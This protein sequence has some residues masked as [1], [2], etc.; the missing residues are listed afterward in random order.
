MFD[1]ACIDNVECT[2]TAKVIRSNVETDSSK[3]QSTNQAENFAH[4]S[5]FYLSGLP[6]GNDKIRGTLSTAEIF[7][8]QKNKTHFLT[9]KIFFLIRGISPDPRTSGSPDLSNLE[10]WQM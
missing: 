10:K 9:S 1:L 6:P 7:V 8:P 5:L 4:Q 2:N 3:A